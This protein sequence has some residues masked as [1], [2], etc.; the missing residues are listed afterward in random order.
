MKPLKVKY[1]IAIMLR[2]GRFYFAIQ[3]EQATYLYKK[4]PD[5]IKGYSLDLENPLPLFE[6]KSLE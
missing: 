4:D 3:T 1:R 2:V 5:P 6:S